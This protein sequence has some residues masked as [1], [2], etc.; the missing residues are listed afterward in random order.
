[1]LLLSLSQ[2]DVK[3][4]PSSSILGWQYRRKQSHDWLVLWRAKYFLCHSSGHKLDAVW[5]RPI[6]ALLTQTGS[7]CW[8]RL[9]SVLAVLHLLWSHWP[10]FHCNKVSHLCVGEGRG[11]LFGTSICLGKA[12]KP[13]FIDVYPCTSAEMQ[14]ESCWRDNV[15]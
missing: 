12:N 13:S 3:L 1:M 5:S 7:G 4:M 11:K 10:W 8:L 2:F 14:L 6:G 15:P 9:T